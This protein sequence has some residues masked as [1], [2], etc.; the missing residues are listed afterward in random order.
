MHVGP[1]GWVGFP[2]TPLVLPLFPCLWGLA[3]I[4]SASAIY[5]SHRPPAPS[6]SDSCNFSALPLYF[7]PP[8]SV[9]SRTTS[10]LAGLRFALW[11]LPYFPYL[12]L[13]FL[14]SCLYPPH[15]PHFPLT[16]IIPSPPTPCSHFLLFPSLALL[17]HP[18][19]A[20]IFARPP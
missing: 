9:F 5:P 2:L 16:F 15:F 19:V 12:S 6:I 8:F 18:R 17:W 14:L 10:Y 4:I 20:P 7:A 11:L 3:R 13:R 1:S